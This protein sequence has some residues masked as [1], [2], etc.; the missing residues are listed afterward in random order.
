MIQV[1]GSRY[2]ANREPPQSGPWKCAH[3]LS[4]R[5]CWGRAAGLPAPDRTFARAPRMSRNQA[6]RK[7]SGHG[8]SKGTHGSARES[9]Q[10]RAQYSGCETVA[11][12]WHAVEPPASVFANCTLI[13]EPPGFPG[14][15]LV[16]INSYGITNKNP[17]QPSHTF[18]GGQCCIASAD[19]DPP[20]AS[21]SRGL[22]RQ[23]GI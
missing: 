7:C 13:L 21:A 18:P 20:P 22:W 4:E 15:A 17:L 16:V 23:C 2:R 11:A 6:E 12:G 1:T 9:R 3:A 19:V 5:G 14:R 10:A 8:K